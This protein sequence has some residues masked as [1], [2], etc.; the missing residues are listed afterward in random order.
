[1]ETQGGN[2]DVLDAVRAGVDSATAGRVF[3]TP[4][5]GDGIVILPVARIAGGGGGGTAPGLEGGR[6]EGAGGGFGTYG[7]GLGV[8]VIK[9]GKVSWRPAIDVNRIVLGG[10]VVAVA[11]LLVLRSVARIYAA[12]HGDT[13]RRRL[14]GRDTVDRKRP[15]R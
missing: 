8:F 9:D 1:M 4:V 3:G 14:R 10:Q 7:R 11:A 5:T 12:T 2:T 13:G 6:S 15:Q